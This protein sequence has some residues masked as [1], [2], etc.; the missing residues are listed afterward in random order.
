M[1]ETIAEKSITVWRKKNTNF[2]VYTALCD[3]EKDKT[4]KYL[5]VCNSKCTS[6][7]KLGKR[8]SSDGNCLTF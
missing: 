5:F 8:V 6:F 4:R 2:T 7:D 1:G 3:C